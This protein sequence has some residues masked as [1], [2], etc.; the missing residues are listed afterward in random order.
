MIANQ[1]MY[2][3]CLAGKELRPVVVIRDQQSA[4]RVSPGWDGGEVKERQVRNFWLR[5]QIY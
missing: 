4:I 1:K 5:V 2:G 3:N